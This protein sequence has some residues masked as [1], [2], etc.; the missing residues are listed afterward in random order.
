MVMPPVPDSSQ[1][2]QKIFTGNRVAKQAMGDAPVQ[3]TVVSATA[4]QVVVTI[5][6]FDRTNQAT[7]TANYEPHPGGGTPPAGT[8]CLL[9]FPPNNRNRTPWVIGF[10]GWPTGGGGGGTDMPI[11]NPT[12]ITTATE[13]PDPISGSDTA[14]WVEFPS[15]ASVMAWGIAGDAFPRVVFGADSGDFVNLGDGTFDPTSDGAFFILDADP[16]RGIF[17]YIGTEDTLIGAAL[18]GG[19]VTNLNGGQTPTGSLGGGLGD[20]AFTIDVPGPWSSAGLWFCTQAGTASTA[21]WMLGMVLG[22][23]SPV[24]AAAFPPNI[25]A[26]WLD[27]LTGTGV[28]VA[29]GTGAG[30]W[31]SLSSAPPVGVSFMEVI[32]PNPGQTNIGSSTYTFTGLSVL[33]SAGAD[34]SLN[35]DTETID[36]ATEG[37]YCIQAL[38]SSFP[39]TA[40]PTGSFS[41]DIDGITGIF[42]GVYASGGFTNA[43]YNA[44]EGWFVNDEFTTTLFSG[45]GSFKLQATAGSGTGYALGVN[46]QHFIITRLT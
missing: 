10:S 12:G 30:D 16:N 43:D 27:V 8:P 4:T 29:T 1:L 24:V 31:A 39:G 26:I 17:P 23:E 42:S 2:F 20:V 21:T 32:G 13:T 38:V 5:D 14:E 11:A 40:P 37:T 7:F 22:K 3:A 36:I 44:S 28:W 34:I 41:L 18:G 35:A 6:G 25:G 9:A 19:V 46:G 15:D 45:P 33:F